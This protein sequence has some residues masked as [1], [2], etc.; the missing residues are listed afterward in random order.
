MITQFNKKKC[1]TLLLKLNLNKY[2]KH[3]TQGS[4]LSLRSKLKF[5]PI[6][7]LWNNYNKSG[8]SLTHIKSLQFKEYSISNKT[9]DMIKLF[10]LKL[11]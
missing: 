8:S 5:L 10:E 7:N 4:K 1:K 2:R 11:T 3:C 6:K 9:D